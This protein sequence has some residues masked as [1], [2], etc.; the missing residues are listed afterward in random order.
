MPYPIAARGKNPLSV[1]FSPLSLSPTLWLKADAGAYSDAGTTLAA[2]NDTVQQWNDQS[3]NG[4]HVLQ[5]TAAD[6]PTYKTNIQNGVAAVRFDGSDYM[7]KSALVTNAASGSVFVVANSTGGGNN[8]VWSATDNTSDSHYLL[9]R[10]GQSGGGA[11]SIITEVN[12]V[13]GAVATDSTFRLYEIHS[14]GTAY[15]IV[16]NGVAESKTV[17]VGSD[18][19]DW[20]A[21]VTSRNIFTVGALNILSGIVQL[22]TGDIGEIAICDTQITGANL[23]NMRSYLNTKWALY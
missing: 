15:T 16:V 6:R 10:F 3:G 17:V 1:P 18:N 23:T 12:T 22:F 20:S 4:N 14:S 9:Y 13:A 8:T 2:N 19:G 7:T 11:Q 5:G 21:D